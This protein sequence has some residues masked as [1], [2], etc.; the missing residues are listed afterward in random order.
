MAIIILYWLS[1]TYWWS[2][3]YQSYRLAGER[4]CLYG[5]VDDAE[6]AQYAQYAQYILHSDS[7]NTVEKFPP[8]PV[9]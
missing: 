4:C 3:T 1:E 2:L 9:W 8:K 7:D 5:I 6:S